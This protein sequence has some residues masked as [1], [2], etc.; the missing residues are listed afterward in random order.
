MFATSW[1]AM[2]TT[3]PPNGS[4][5]CTRNRFR[6]V[7]FILVHFWASSKHTISQPTPR[8]S[9]RPSSLVNIDQQRGSTTRKT[10]TYSPWFS[11]WSWSMKVEDWLIRNNL[12]SE[13]RRCG[14][15][16]FFSCNRLELNFLTWIQK[17]Y[18]NIYLKKLFC[19]LTRLA[20]NWSRNEMFLSPFFCF[21]RLNRI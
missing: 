10:T 8:S 3:S 15:K 21:M 18:R 4:L 11:T 2:K 6:K 12:S 1:V 19:L 5:N 9:F 17:N 13:S 14:D 20:A 16:L 7:F